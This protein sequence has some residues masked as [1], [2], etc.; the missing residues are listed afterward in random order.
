M[1]VTTF[2]ADPEKQF[3]NWLAGFDFEIK[4]VA[5]IPGPEVK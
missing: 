1:D 3:G 5:R 2:H 4:V